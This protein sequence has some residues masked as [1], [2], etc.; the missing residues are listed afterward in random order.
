MG[1]GNDRSRQESR[2]RH[3]QVFGYTCETCGLPTK[4]MVGLRRP[5]S[6]SPLPQYRKIELC[7]CTTPERKKASKSPDN[8]Q[9]NSNRDGNQLVTEIEKLGALLAS[10]V[11]TR[12]QFDAAMKKLLDS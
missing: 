7:K 9:Q 2:D 11:L 4:N 10:G 6:N 3:R 12:E 1:L 5:S 8:S